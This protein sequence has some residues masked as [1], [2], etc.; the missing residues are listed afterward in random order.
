MRQRLNAHSIGL[1]LQALFTTPGGK[2]RALSGPQSRNS[3]L[4]SV[5]YRYWNSPR[6]AVTAIAGLSL[7]HNLLV[8]PARLCDKDIEPDA[9]R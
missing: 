2:W 7:R 3:Y 8:T 1:V 9:L 5:T 4:R 6:I